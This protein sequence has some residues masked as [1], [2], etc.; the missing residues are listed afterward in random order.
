MHNATSSGIK[1]WGQFD[2]TKHPTCNSIP[3]G[4]IFQSIERKGVK[5]CIKL[6]LQAMPSDANL[7]S[8]SCNL[9]NMS[10]AAFPCKALWD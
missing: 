6:H 1:A 7:V 4:V 8:G 9:Q 10:G 3:R 5:D 2:G